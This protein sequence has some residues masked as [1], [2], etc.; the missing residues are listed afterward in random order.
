ML[1]KEMDEAS[2]QAIGHAFGYYDYGPEKKG[3]IACFRSPDAAAEYICGFVRCVLADGFLHTTSERGEGYIAYKLPGQKVSFHAARLLLQGIRRSMN[4]RQIIRFAKAISQ[5]GPSLEDVLKKEK[6]PCIYVGMVCVREAYQGQGYMRKVMDLAFAEGDR[7][8][9][10]VILD[11][12]AQSKCEKYQHV[13]MQL[14]ATRSFGEFG[15]MYDLIRYPKTEKE[16]A[17]NV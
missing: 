2:I 14:A 17:Q 13:V 15:T 6:K 1:V 12:D 8:G 7:L 3:L 5:G 16:G 4:L 11:T 10:P 9:I